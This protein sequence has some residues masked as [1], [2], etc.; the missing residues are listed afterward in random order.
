[1]NKAAKISYIKSVIRNMGE[2][3]LSK[4]NHFVLPYLKYDEFSCQL[5]VKMY[6]HRVETVTLDTESGKGLD[7]DYIQYEDLEDHIVEQLLYIVQEW[8]E[9]QLQSK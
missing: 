5:P 9:M 2:I 3:D 8:E 7:V 1:M 4:E 6:E